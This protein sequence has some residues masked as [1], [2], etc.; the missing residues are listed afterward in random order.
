[1][2]VAAKGTLNTAIDSPYLNGLITACGVFVAFICASTITRAKDLDSID[3]LFARTSLLTFIAAVLKLSV[4]L[5]SGYP[6][7]LTELG[8]V[9]SGLNLCALTTW[10]ILHTLLRHP[11]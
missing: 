6:T 9:S 3:I 11:N 8:L 1:M 5:E 4:Q 10:S 7:T 2:I